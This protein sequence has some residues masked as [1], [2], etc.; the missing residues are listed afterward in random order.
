MSILNRGLDGPSVATAAKFSR[1][2]NINPNDPVEAWYTATNPL[3]NI[4][5]MNGAAIEK[6]DGGEYR[7]YFWDECQYGQGKYQWKVILTSGGVWPDRKEDFDNFC[8]IEVP[9]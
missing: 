8:G 6:L 4:S 5:A 3:D 2:Y 7:Y 9:W 1:A